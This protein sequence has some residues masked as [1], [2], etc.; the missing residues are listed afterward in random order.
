MW[1]TH[2]TKTISIEHIKLMPYSK[3]NVRLAA[4]VLSSTVSKVLLAYGPPEVAETAHFCSLIDC[5]LTL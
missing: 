2:L 4:Q 5:F 3:M 1:F